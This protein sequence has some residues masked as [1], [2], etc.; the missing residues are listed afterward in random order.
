MPEGTSV[1]GTVYL[2]VLKKKLPIFM[3][4][5][6]YTHFQHDGAPCYQR[7]AVKKWLDDNGFQILG[8]WPGNSLDLN[9]IE[10][11]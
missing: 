7:K 1:N 4:I 6:C 11:C 2:N 8:P 3:E 10:N 9:P 5:N